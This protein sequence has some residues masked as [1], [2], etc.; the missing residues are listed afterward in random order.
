MKRSLFP[1]ITAGILLAGA[2]IGTAAIRALIAPPV[3]TTISAGVQNVPSIPG[4]TADQLLFHPW[5]SYALE[6]RSP[7]TKPFLEDPQSELNLAMRTLVPIVMEQGA[8][9]SDALL[10]QFLPLVMLPSGWDL[11]YEPE[12][13][14]SRLEWSADNNG[15]EFHVYLKD[16]PAELSLED[17]KTGV[18]LSCG[19]S[20]SRSSVNGFSLVAEPAQEVSVSDEAR[21]AALDKVDSDLYDLFQMRRLCDSLYYGE[22][23]SAYLTLHYAS[24]ADM[25]I[26]A[27]AVVEESWEQYFRHPSGLGPYLLHLQDA[28]S[29][30]LAVIYSLLESCLLIQDDVPQDLDLDTMLDRLEEFHSW[31]LQRI[32]TPTQIVLLFHNPYVGTIG[33]Y[34]DI[35]LACYAGVGFSY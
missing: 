15:R 21:Q 31:S 16:L 23:D 24:A 22:V 11:T 14:E 20:C 9:D 26:L 6:K 18:S 17:S 5:D 13:L 28:T 35:T 19:I 3:G 12:D 34:Y 33:F 30:G 10:Q 25:L 32:S 2:L 27:P 7:L 29:G 1:L 8:E 4:L